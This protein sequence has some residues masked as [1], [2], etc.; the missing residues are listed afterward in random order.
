MVITKKDKKLIL[1]ILSIA[2]V[3]WLIFH[4]SSSFSTKINFLNS[5]IKDLTSKDTI[6]LN[7]S[8]NIKT[9]DLENRIIL[10]DFWTYAC[11][12]CLHMIPEIKK[13]EEVF[14]DRLTV[15][16]VHSGKFNNEKETKSIRNAILKHDISH[17]V[18]NDADF[19]IWN[20]FKISS[21]P[22]ILLIDPKGRIKKKYEGEISSS[23]LEKDIK[24]LIKKYRYQLNDKE[25][26]IVLE[27]NET[28]DHVLKFPEKIIFAK[29][30]SY[31]NVSKTNVLIVANSGKNSIFITNLNGQTLLEIGS[32]DSGFLDGNISVAKFNSPRGLLFKNNILYV[33]DTENHALRQIDFKNEEVKTLSG[34]G[35]RGAI[36]GGKNKAKDI[37]LASPWDLEFFPDSNNIIIANAGTH[38]LLKYDISEKT[39]NNFAGNGNEDLIDGANPQN[40]LAQPSGLSASGNKLYFV[41]SESSSLRMVTKSGEVS[42]LIGKGLF[43][44][45]YKNGIKK[46]ALLQH[47]AGIYADDTGIYIADT[48]NHVIRKYNF[49][50]KEIYDYS[51]SLRGYGVGSKKET[52]YDEP[53]GLVGFLGKLYIADTNN[54]RIIELNSN[55]SSKVIDI[56]PELKIPT[57][58]LLEY[59]PNLERVPTKKVR[60]GDQVKLIF[61]MDDGW[62]IN[63][64]APSFFNL[65][66]I[67]NKKEA[68]LI[69]SFT[70]STIRSGSVKLPKLLK[71]HQ[72]Y[73]QG[74][75]YYCEDKKDSLCLIKSYEQN[76]I[77]STFGAKEIQLNFIYQ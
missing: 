39:I 77:P 24:K 15:I 50:T 11:V 55:K 67:K 72:Y 47:P 19:K 65:V 30:F 7:S 66:E 68:N 6:W 54:N 18:V 22:T 58:G 9:S 75:V 8:R 57:E 69:A 74:T 40:S 23:Q 36:V 13:L 16:G 20:S 31:K 76:L 37:S 35:L 43:D 51:G 3:L 61:N 48:L 2:T 46:D 26:P 27:R 49:K 29:D 10:L 14:G 33:A 44:F 32:E 41:D 70:E 17:L 25:L 4:L 42:T 12:N 5:Q 52:S 38:Q 56:L 53:G 63:Q 64:S 1:L 34:N 60:I 45:G 62:K 73:L 59:L 28:I 71:D 21:W